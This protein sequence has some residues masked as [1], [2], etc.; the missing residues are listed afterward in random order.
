MKIEQFESDWRRTEFRRIVF[1]LKFLWLCAAA[2]VAIFAHASQYQEHMRPDYYSIEVGSSLPGNPAQLVQIWAHVKTHDSTYRAA[3]PNRVVR[4]PSSEIKFNWSAG[5][6]LAGASERL[7]L[8]WRWTNEYNWRN[9]LISEGFRSPMNGYLL[10]P[11]LVLNW[12][13][14]AYGQVEMRFLLRGT[15]GRVR[16]DG[17]E[18]QPVTLIVAPEKPAAS[19]RFTKQWQTIQL[20]RIV[21][22]KSFE[23]DYERERIANQIREL[24]PEDSGRIRMFAHV[25]FDDDGVLKYPLNATHSEH[26]E[27]SVAF[28]P[29]IEIPQTAR[30]M[31]IWFSAFFQNRDY[32]DSNFGQN[33][34]FVIT[35]F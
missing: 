23:L 5:S 33:Y 20:G 34:K 18:F 32:F 6:A 7:E 22:G 27:R 15:D 9:K 3:L 29:T 30:T 14:G 1:I 17:S 4:G 8:V 13:E 10:T 16:W 11:P 2:G 19:V 28:M 12:G 26:P 35:P 24:H 31:N 21:S 25:Q